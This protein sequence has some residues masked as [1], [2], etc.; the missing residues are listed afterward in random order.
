LD[1]LVKKTAEYV[2]FVGCELDKCDRSFIL[3]GH[4]KQQRAIALRTMIA[5]FGIWREGRSN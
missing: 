2:G 5:V 3:D 1:D 4:Q